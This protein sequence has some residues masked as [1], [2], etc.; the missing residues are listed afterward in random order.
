MSD[1]NIVT[2]QAILSCYPKLAPVLSALRVDPHAKISYDGMAGGLSWSD[3][4]PN[5][6]TW[7]EQNSVRPLLRYRT[8]LI[9]GEPDENLKQFWSAAGQAFPT[10][11][12][13]NHERCMSS[14]QLAKNLTELEGAWEEALNG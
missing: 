13:F 4:L 12:G 14:P 6:L 2:L 3:E 5:E 10:W 11:I 8:T 1:D 9:L 7:I